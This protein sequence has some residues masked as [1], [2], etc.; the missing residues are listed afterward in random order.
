MT[1]PPPPSLALRTGAPFDVLLLDVNLPDQTGWDV[2][3]AL[4]G[5]HVP[6]VIVL[7]ALRPTQHR[8][9]EFRPAAVLLKPFPM[10]ALVRLVGRV[11]RTHYPTR[12]AYSQLR[13][14]DFAEK[15]ELW[16]ADLLFMVVTILAFA[17][18]VAFAFA[19]D[20]L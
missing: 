5:A 10:D 16:M 9:D 12:C 7:T 18:L 14:V 3:R 2:L 11:L 19:C 1:A 4:E 6:P 17:V 13:P 20:R 15:R 8:L